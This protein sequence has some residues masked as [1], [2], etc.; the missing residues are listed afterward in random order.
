[1]ALRDAVGLKR[2]VVDTYQ[3]VSGTGAE[4]LGELESAD[5]RHVTGEEPVANVYP[6]PI[7]FNALPEIDV[8]LD[9]GYTKEEWKV[10]NENRKIL[11]CRICASRA[12]PSGSGVREPFRGGP[13][14]DSRAVTPDRR[15][16]CS[17]RC[18]A[19]SCRTTRRA[20]TT[21]SPRRRRDA[22][23][24]SSGASV[25]I[26]SIATT[27]ASPSGSYPTTCA[28]ARRRTPSSSAEVLRERGLDPSGR[29][30]RSDR[31]YRA[32]EV[33]QHGFAEATA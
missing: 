18:R 29:H 31:P 21:R 9:N 32:P 19:S 22:T 23:R 12:R 16:S 6:H 2:V 11:A 26:V 27:A 5:P 10:V 30:A 33:R 13:C 20:T 7:A 24:S 14:R 28:R 8:F 15:A 3:S 4:A 25:A 1:M 17:R